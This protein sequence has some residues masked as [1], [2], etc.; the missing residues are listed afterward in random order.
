MKIVGIDADYTQIRNVINALYKMRLK[1][2]WP[3]QIQILLNEIC[4]LH[5]RCIMNT[6][7]DEFMKKHKKTF[8]DNIYNYDDKVLIL[9]LDRDI[10][11]PE[12][13]THLNI[14]TYRTGNLDC[15]PISLEYLSIGHLNKE[16]LNLPM[17]LHLIKVRWSYDGSKEIKLPYGCELQ[18]FI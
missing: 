12:G 4:D 10:V 11:F 18:I 9:I 8:I 7:L 14:I 16:L 3:P 17:S 1:W 13:T 15:L 2:Y 5:S 6:Y